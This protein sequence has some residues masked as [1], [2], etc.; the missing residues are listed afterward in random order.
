[1]WRVTIFAIF[2]CS[3]LACGGG[4]ENGSC[5][6]SGDECESGACVCGSDDTGRPS[7]VCIEQPPENSFIL[8]GCTAVCRHED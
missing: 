4:K 1:M 5:C 7:G 2:S 8:M 6:D 3:L